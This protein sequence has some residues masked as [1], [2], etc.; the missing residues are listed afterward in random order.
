MTAPAQADYLTLTCFRRTRG[1]GRGTCP[2]QTKVEHA[3]AAGAVGVMIMNEGTNGR[4]DA[5][6]GLMN[7]PAAIPVVGVPYERGR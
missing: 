4:T 2:F 6:S 3:V 7:K 1:R 5:F